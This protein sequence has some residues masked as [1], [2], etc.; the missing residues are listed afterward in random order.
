MNWNPDRH[1]QNSLLNENI[2]RSKQNLQFLVEQLLN[3]LGGQHAFSNYRG[4]FPYWISQIEPLR[5]F[6]LLKFSIFF[7]ENRQSTIEH[8]I[9]FSKMSRT[10]SKWIFKNEKFSF[11]FNLNGFCLVFKCL[12]KFKAYMGIIGKNCF[13]INFIVWK[14]KLVLWIWYTLENFPL[15]W[16]MIAYMDFDKLEV[17]VFLSGQK[18]NGENCYGKFQLCHKKKVG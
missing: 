12:L 2:K 11:F 13:I 14:L 7:D 8:I 4:F 15:K 17:I 1:N 16:L 6:K 10:Y 3:E 5:R 9:Q 18:W